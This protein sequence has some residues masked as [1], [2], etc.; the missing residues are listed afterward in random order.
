MTH[1]FQLPTE[2]EMENLITQAYE[3][4]PIPDQSRLSLLEG[5][6]LYKAR[7]NKPQK[8][9]NKIPWWIVLVLAGSFASAAWWAG[10]V[11]FV[12]ENEKQQQEQ[13]NLMNE[14]KTGMNTEKQ[15]KQE[16]HKENHSYQ[17][18]DTRVIYQ[19]EGF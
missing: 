3:S 10:E 15:N 9:L 13:L 8:N 11:W 17:S 18:R 12:N 16:Q 4:M 6:L 1:N 2:A 5:K 19:R 7:K 14:S